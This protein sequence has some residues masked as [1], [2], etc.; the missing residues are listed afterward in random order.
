MGSYNSTRRADRTEILAFPIAFQSE[1]YKV[2]ASSKRVNPNSDG[3]RVMI[4]S[5]TLTQ[6][7]IWLDYYTDYIEYV[8]IGR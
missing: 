1:C 4:K 8:A 7:Q 3:G 5:A 2:I 6:V